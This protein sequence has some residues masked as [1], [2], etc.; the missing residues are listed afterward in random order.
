MKKILIEAYHSKVKAGSIHFDS[1]QI[2]ILEQLQILLDS[3]SKP[4]IVV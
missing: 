2:F 3:L 1:A 4:K